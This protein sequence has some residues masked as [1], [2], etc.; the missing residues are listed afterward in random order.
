MQKKIRFWAAAMVFSVVL[1]LF[2]SCHQSGRATEDLLNEFLLLYGASEGSIYTSKAKEY[3]KGALPDGMAD[4]LFLEENGE[5][6]LALCTEYAIYLSPSFSGG[7]VGFFRC[8]SE[9]DALR[10]RKM[11]NARINRLQQSA[12]QTSTAILFTYG[13]DTVLVCLPDAELARQIC[14]RLY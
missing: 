9:A 7:E 1:L 11:L 3:E 8:K 6:A 5:N 12:W 2:S 4:L 10:V 14:A 13:L